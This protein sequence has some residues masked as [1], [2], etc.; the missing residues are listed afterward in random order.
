MKAQG[1]ATAKR[2]DTENKLNETL[3][4]RIKACRENKTKQETR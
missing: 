1:M 3:K 4:P 2:R